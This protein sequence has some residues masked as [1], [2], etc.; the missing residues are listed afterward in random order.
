M[1]HDIQTHREYRL[2]D[3]AIELAKV[4]GIL[5]VVDKGQS[6]SKWV[7]MPLDKIDVHLSQ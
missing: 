6:V 5:A 4:S 7:G 3:S 1:D 2:Q